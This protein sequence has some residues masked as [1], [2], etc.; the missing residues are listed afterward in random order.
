M[1][2]LFFV[3]SGFLMVVAMTGIASATLINGDFETTTGGYTGIV[4]GYQLDALG[5]SGNGTWDVYR[6]IDGWATYNGPGIEIQKNTVVQAHSG[7]H[8]VELDSHGADPSNSAMVQYVDLETGRYELS[9]W[10]R[11]RTDTVGDNGIDVFLLNPEQNVVFS[12]NSIK[13][14][15]AD[16]TKFTVPLFVE[17]ADQWGIGFNASGNDN[18]LGGFIDTVE[19]NSVPEPATM[20]LLG[21]ALIGLA[22]LRRRFKK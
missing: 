20:L 10:Y 18:T 6:I 4:H 14:D 12:V 2:K 19:L 17:I 13:S 3:L 11:P 8:Y 9:F 22:G 1:K 15:I 5:D 16:W 21:T 7:E